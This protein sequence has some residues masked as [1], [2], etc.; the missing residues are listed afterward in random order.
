LVAFYLPMTL[1]LAAGL[2]LFHKIP[3]GYNRT[4]CADNWTLTERMTIVLNC[5]SP[6]YLHLAREP[7][8]LFL[9]TSN[10]QSRPG[11]VLL[12]ALL[13]R[14]FPSSHALSGL[15]ARVAG[16][17]L[18]EFT[19]DLF[20][21][22]LPYLA[23]NFA[24]SWI[25]VALYGALTG[26]RRGQSMAVLLA[27]CL[28]LL[29][30]VVKAFLFSPNT[31]LLAILAPLSALWCYSQIRRGRYGSIWQLALLALA[32][33][34]AVTAYALFL[35]VLP[36]VWLALWQREREEGGRGWKRS[37]VAKAL[38]SAFLCFLPAASWYVWVRV[39]TGQF[40]F[41]EARNYSEVVW[42]WAGL[43]TN[44]VAAMARLVD[45]V[46]RLAIMAI[47]QAVPALGLVILAFVVTFR[48]GK[49]EMSLRDRAFLAPL[50]VSLLCLT[51]FAVAGIMADRRAYSAVP[52]IIVVAGMM[53]DRVTSQG[54]RR[55]KLALTAGTAVLVIGQ[56]VILLAKVGPFS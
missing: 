55:E 37:L 12:A 19:L 23:L 14:V 42:L 17:P 43:N 30:D 11:L 36:M 53:I 51:F 4:H 16:H 39:T 8:D 47:R 6:E 48:G 41:S 56:A 24:F 49:P 7:Q 3:E 10:R 25:S 29:N 28:L 31:A 22:Y 50:A 45:N 35:V 21:T 33:G 54:G 52:P 26:C 20:S 34:L 2:L 1:L 44:P 40:N 27:G 18:D 13:A 9:P 15:L 38:L 32:V 5:D 46:L